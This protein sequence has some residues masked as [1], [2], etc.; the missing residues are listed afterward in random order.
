[1]TA[2]EIAV[3]AGKYATMYGFPNEIR[4]YMYEM[5]KSG[6]FIR[7]I[8]YNAKLDAYYVYMTM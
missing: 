6:A 8:Q 2:K 7:R 1:M 5:R 3:F 4:Y